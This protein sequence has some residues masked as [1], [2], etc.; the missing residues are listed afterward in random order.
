MST[1]TLD[2]LSEWSIKWGKILHLHTILAVHSVIV[3]IR[4]R[5]GNGVNLFDETQQIDYFYCATSW[6]AISVEN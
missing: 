5:R 3:K 1:A 4:M 6:E 2:L